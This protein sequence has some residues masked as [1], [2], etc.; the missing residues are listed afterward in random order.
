MYLRLYL[1]RTVLY[2]ERARAEE[3]EDLADKAAKLREAAADRLCESKGLPPEWRDF[4]SE[5]AGKHTKLLK[6]TEAEAA[7]QARVQELVNATYN[8]WGGLGLQ[9]RTRDRGK[10]P[11]AK[12]LEVMS[13]VHVQNA[14]N[15]VNYR[16]R[17]AE[18]SREITSEV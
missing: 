7:L 13:V 12:R 10:E 4:V 5:L 3:H 14:E 6:K 15:F 16:V 9:T 11:V 17:L 18:I 8:G 1:H 2:Q